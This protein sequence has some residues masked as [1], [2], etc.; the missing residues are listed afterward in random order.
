MI[1]NPLLY[2]LVERLNALRSPGVRADD[3]D[4]EQQHLDRLL[5]ERGQSDISWQEIVLAEYVMLDRLDLA[6]VP[7]RTHHWF[8]EYLTVQGP[9]RTTRVG[10]FSDL[11]ELLDP[12]GKFLAIRALARA[13]ER[14]A[15]ELEHCVDHVAASD[16]SRLGQRTVELTNVLVDVWLSEDAIDRDE[17]RVNGRPMPWWFQDAIRIV[18]RVGSRREQLEAT[19]RARGDRLDE[20]TARNLTRPSEQF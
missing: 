19:L 11:Y 16:D 9:P 3:S 15:H 8:L 18:R 1:K 4:L 5:A 14:G 20:D 13:G 17:K 10:F 6:A 2:L 7:T 12:V